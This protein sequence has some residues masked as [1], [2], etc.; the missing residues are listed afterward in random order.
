VNGAI[1]SRGT[2]AAIAFAFGDMLAR[3]SADVRVR[4]GEI[5]GSGTVGGGS[6]L[7]VREQTLGR[8]LEPGDE[9]VLEI[10]RLGRLATPIVARPERR[11]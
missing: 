6:L 11:A 7:E 3:A 5:L 10:E 9:V 4:P 8:Y 2:W 1:T